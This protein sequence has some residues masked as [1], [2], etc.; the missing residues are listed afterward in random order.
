[1]D[2]TPKHHNGAFDASDGVPTHREKDDL[3][4]DG[5]LSSAPAYRT[6]YDDTTGEIYDPYGGKKIGMFRVCSQL[7]LERIHTDSQ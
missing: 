7:C 4:S 6:D 1:M 3:T 5:Q 2:R